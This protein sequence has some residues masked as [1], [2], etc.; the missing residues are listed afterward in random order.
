MKFFAGLGLIT[1]KEKQQEKTERERQLEAALTE[2]TIL[3]A[4]QQAQIEQAIMELT[5]MIGGME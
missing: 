4:E 2:M 3:F 1:N 5:M